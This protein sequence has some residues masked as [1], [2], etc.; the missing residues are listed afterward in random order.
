[1]GGT[2]PGAAHRHVR[3]EFGS[4]LRRLRR[5][6]GLTQQAL[7]ARAGLS[8]G[9]VHTLESGRR[10]RPQRA[11][12]A[13][14]C[15][16]LGLSAYD[17]RRLEDAARGETVAE[18]QPPDDF[19]GREE[20]L[21]AIAGLL[22]ADRREGTVAVSAVS[23]M[24]GV[25]KTALAVQVSRRV[26]DA[27]PDGTLWVDLEGFGPT[28]PA[29]PYDAVCHVLRLLGTP[30]AAIPATLN[31]ATARYRSATA[32]RRLLIVLDNAADHE[33][34]LPLLP[35][36]SGCAVVVTS[37]RLLSVIPGARHLH[38]DVLSPAESVVLLGRVVGDT[39]SLG[40]GPE[41]D[42]LVEQC[43]RL[44]L[45]LRIVAARLAA[46]PQLTV[47]RLASRLRDER[48]A[49]DQLTDGD[50]G[51]RASLSFSLTD[52][53]GGDADDAEAA[54]ALPLLALLDSGDFDTRLA[55]AQLDRTPAG[56]ARL[57]GRLVDVN[58]LEALDTERY[59]LHDLVRAYAREDARRD[60]GAAEIEAARLRVLDLYAAM[61]WRCEQ[62]AG[63]KALSEQWMDPVWIGPARD[64]DDLD[65]ILDWLDHERVY[66]VDGVRAAAA[67]SDEQR[68]LAVRIGCGINRFCVRQK[69]WLEWRDLSLAALEALAGTHDEVAEAQL[70]F[71]LGLAYGEFDEYGPAAEQ[72][73]RVVEIS[74]RIG[75]G[76]AQVMSTVNL[77][78]LLER[79][80]LVAEGI[81]M[82]RWGLRLAQEF[83]DGEYE[84]WAHL[85]LGMVAGRA[86]L[87]AEQ[88]ECYDRALAL[89]EMDDSSTLARFHLQIGRSLV[90]SGRSDEALTHLGRS[91]DL[92]SAAG[93][94]L[95]Q[96]ESHDE[97]G[98]ALIALDRPDEAIEILRAGLR[99]ARDG[100]L[101]DREASI[102]Q[103]LAD[104][105][106][107]AGDD[108]EADRS[109]R[110]AAEIR[111]HYGLVVRG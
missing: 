73:R 4:L 86:G 26:R 76:E 87:R 64:E 34:V 50:A 15:E 49:L 95:R 69:R 57:L 24:G 82:A 19:V 59:R 41:I 35:G 62:L 109:R 32:D 104:A 100:Q 108:V 61:A 20:E 40:S 29:D 25:G 30:P 92:F 75:A 38:L 85:V 98:R 88:A 60:V 48:V 97:L 67:G 52:L 84:A 105:H 65:A 1:M 9:A 102:H 96:A 39:R 3:T 51:V 58:L 103:Q 80:G 56:A 90:E 70:R 10:H 37:R 77:A 66:V 107:A 106:T 72:L 71:N 78:R 42:D 5:D 110:A 22:T 45:A 18:A 53:R 44:P 81:E 79:Q 63:M 101:W 83:G 33:Q 12:V 43:G 74:A 89:A 23:G 21:S 94:P 36:G 28:V 13:L 31:E 8:A 91:R 55:A 93:A 111:A 2:D 6:A 99:L 54:A 11:T 68:R 46:R 7:A 16:A 47:A 27:F 17:R 14:L